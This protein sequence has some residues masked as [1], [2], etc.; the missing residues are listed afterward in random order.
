M[1]ELSHRCRDY[2]HSRLSVNSNS[3]DNQEL[4]DLDSTYSYHSSLNAHEGCILLSYHEDEFQLLQK[5]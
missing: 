2:N 3:K 5:R 4:S 1:I